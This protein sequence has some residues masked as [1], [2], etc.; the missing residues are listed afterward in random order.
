VRPDELT[1]ILEGQGMAPD[2]AAAKVHLYETCKALRLKLDWSP[3]EHAL[4]IPG[5]LE[6]FG[7]HTD[8]AGGRTLVAALPRGFA[9]IAGSGRPSAPRVTVADATTGE[10]ATL[11]AIGHQPAWAP[12]LDAVVRR[13]SRNFP[14][15][16]LSA[17][18]VF[19]S[20]LPPA[21]GM[22][23]SSA[24]MVGLAAAL[25]QIA[26][27]ESHEDWRRNISSALDAAAYYACIENGA[28]FRGLPGDLGVGTHGGSEDHAAILCATP[29]ELTAFGFVPLTL[30]ARATVPSEWRFIVASSG[31]RAEKTRAARDAYNALSRDASALLQLWNAHEATAASLGEALATH[32]LAAKRL[33]DLV[34]ESS[35]TGSTREALTRRLTHFILEDRRVPDAVAAFGSTDA[36]ALAELA[37]S[38]QRDAEALLQNQIPETVEL[39]AAARR[40]GAIGASG[41][42][43]G[44]GGSVWAVVERDAA[45][46]FPTRWLAACRP[47]CPPD[48][49]AFDASPAP[50]L[51]RLEPRRLL[52]AKRIHGIDA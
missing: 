30:I 38:S 9:L 33:I 4:W 50:P 10:I 45:P 27:I 39:V 37:A 19:A 28:T 43:A 5:R 48:A 31:V 6:V 40:L 1:A 7:K 11:P 15:A 42:G 18:I 13:L 14:G 3:P 26:E 36:S 32:P 20:D 21:A 51:M 2:L 29:S 17:E 12:Y 16:T 34:E 47:A 44:F 46:D 22:S 49:V 35:R 25:V 8:Y 23:S 41:F 52:R 24:L